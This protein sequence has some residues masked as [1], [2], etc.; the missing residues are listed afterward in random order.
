VLEKKEEWERGRRREAWLKGYKEGH[1]LC[2][3]PSRHEGHHSYWCLILHRGKRMSTS[4]SRTSAWAASC[5]PPSLL[6]LLT[7]LT[8]SR[9]GKYFLMVH[10]WK[11]FLKRVKMKKY[12]TNLTHLVSAGASMLI[13]E[14][15]QFAT[16]WGNL[17]DYWIR[18]CSEFMCKGGR[19]NFVFFDDISYKG[20]CIWYCI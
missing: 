19:C 15:L 18:A 11:L 12:T 9:Y 17:R 16:R 20:H 7:S 4:T 10:L 6:A 5:S 13:V 14:W 1:H 3:C 2:R 8:E